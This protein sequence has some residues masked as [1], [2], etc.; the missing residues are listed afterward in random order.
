MRNESTATWRLVDMPLMGSFFRME[1]TAPRGE[2]IVFYREHGQ[3]KAARVMSEKEGYALYETLTAMPPVGRD[4]FSHLVGFW[5]GTLRAGIVTNPTFILSNYIRDQFAAFILRPDY[6]PLLSGLRGI[7]SEVTQGEA[8]KLYGLGG[9]VSAGAIV[10]PVE[11][12]VK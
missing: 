8:A 1:K 7:W 4:L 3:L 2:P 6:F 10:G 9:G 5:S 12:A 11:D